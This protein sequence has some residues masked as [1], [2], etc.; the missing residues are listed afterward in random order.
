MLQIEPLVMITMLVPCI[1]ALV[2]WLIG[3][4]YEKIQ[5]VTA[6][7]FSITA[8]ISSIAMLWVY[9]S[10][11]ILSFKMGSSF[12][13]F[14]F[15]TDGLGLYLSLVATVI[16]ALAIIFSVDYMKGDPQLGRYYSFVLFFI[17]AM[18]GLV[19]TSN[20]LLM[21]VFWEITALCSYALISFYNDD[22]KAVAGGIKALIVTQFGGLGLLLAAA[23]LFAYTGSFDINIFISNPTLLPSNVLAVLAFGMLIAAAAKSAQFPFQTWLPD[24]MEAPSP[25][26]ALIHAATMV[27]AGVYLLARFYPAF[28]DVP[29]WTLSVMVVGMI[30]ALMAALMALVANDL[31]RVLAYSTVSQLGYMVYAVGAGGILASQFHLFSH[32]VFKALLFLAAGAVIHS[33]GTRDMREMGGLGKE[34]PFARTVFII[35]ALA[36]AGI[37]IFNG[38]WSKELILEAGLEHGNP[39]WIYVVMLIVAGITALYTVRCV[40][41]VFYGEKKLEEHIHPIGK[42]MKIALAPLGFGAITTWLLIGPFSKMMSTSLPMHSI[43]ELNLGHLF[44]HVLLAPATW[45]A[46]AIIALGIMTWVG[47]AALGGIQQ[48]LKPIARMADVSFGF[49][50]INKLIVDATQKVGESLR[51]TQTGK[52]NWNVFYILIALVVV[53]GVLIIGA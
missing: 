38:F 19:L 24:A 14:T 45:I 43:N 3:N 52:L 22:P 42:N 2:V 39:I 6:V 48:A 11:T 49:E 53:F 25:I 20:L 15:I 34:L 36:L 29:G 18:V 37:P 32:S 4:R 27:N 44:N 8:A 13:D 41:L 5:H 31:K 12:G 7:V 26:S 9:K 33:V 35:G 47:R 16:G 30:S 17:G 50:K 28:K 23:L 10:G 1:G 46:L 40:Y 51:V 21:F